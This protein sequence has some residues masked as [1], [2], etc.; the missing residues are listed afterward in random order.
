MVKPPSD[1]SYALGFLKCTVIFPCDSSW[2][3]ITFFRGYQLCPSC[4]DAF[5]WWFFSL[6]TPTR[7]PRF[8]C[9]LFSASRWLFVGWEYK[10]LI[11]A[12]QRG[13]Q[14]RRIHCFHLEPTCLQAASSTWWPCPPQGH[15][16][17]PHHH[18]KGPVLVLT[19]QEA[20]SSTPDPLEVV[21]IRLPHEI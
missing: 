8:T 6:E 15:S 13:I 19:A 9:Y 2:T 17:P 5:R 4:E 10:G 3:G 18:A 20:C 12:Q 21:Q 16:P 7:V 1:H 11:W 14:L